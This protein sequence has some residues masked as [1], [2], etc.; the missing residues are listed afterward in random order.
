MISQTGPGSGARPRAAR[1]CLMTIYLSESLGVRQLCASLRARG[2]ECE[3]VF[4][5][6]FRWEVLTPV[7]TREEELLF[8]LLQDFQPDLVGISITSSLTS[9]LAYEV[10]DKIR[11][12]LG[13]K[14]I[15]GG[16]HPSV[17]PEESLEHA[18]FIC[19]GEGE[20]A[21]LELVARLVCG[22]AT[23]DLPNIWT[24]KD[25]QV[26]RNE[27]RPLV[28]DLDQ[29]PFAAFGDEQCL[30]VEDDTIYRYDPAMRG[31]VYHTIASR[32][33][34][35]FNC[36]F[37]GGTFLR[38][39]LY[40]GK[41]KRRRYRSVDHLISEIKQARERWPQLES[42]MFWDEVFGVRPPEGWLEEFCERFPRELGMSFM[43]WGH[44]G[45]VTDPLIKQLKAAGLT[46]VVVGVE[47]GSEQ[48][49]REVLNRRETNEQVIRVRGDPAALWRGSG[50]RFHRGSPVA[51]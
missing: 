4:L 44:P 37:C 47:S 16:A 49:R 5:K 34:C 30:L 36:S 2:H 29:Y 21:L 10:A 38:H 42:V 51:E 12:K 28:Q 33:T 23:D 31:P 25:G 11:A 39:V 22:G 46:R 45:L 19:Q 27:V 9:D 43:T 40:A 6:Q 24:V 32:M 26:C 50:L 1:V 14:V 48:V 18:D 3:L 41:G 15:L 35:P 20:E 7:S 8:S 13:V 17:A